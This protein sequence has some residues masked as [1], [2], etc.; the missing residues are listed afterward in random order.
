MLY[1]VPII[2]SSSAFGLR[3]GLL[4]VLAAFALM[5]PRALFISSNP[6]QAMWETLI[7]TAIGSTAPFGMERYKRQEAQLEVTR[8]RLESTQRE[9]VTKV[10]ISREQERQLLVINAFSAM[11]SQPL[12]LEQ[13]MKST[14]GMVMDLME[15]EVVMVFALYDKAESLRL[16]AYKGIGDSFAKHL[17]GM[18]LCENPCGRMIKTGEPF[19]LSDIAKG[20]ILHNL[21]VSGKSLK[22][23]LSVPLLAHGEVMGTLCVAASSGRHLKEPDIELLLALGKLIGIAIYNHYLYCERKT[24]TEKLELSEKKYRQLFENAHAAIWV[25]DL[26]GKVIE[27]NQAAAELFG[28]KLPGLIGADSR[29]LFSR[30]D[31]AVSAAVQKNLLS[32][33]RKQQPFRQE[34]IRRDGTKAYAMLTANLVSNNE[35]PSG[36]QFIGR[37]I[38]KEVR[39]QENER[40]YLQQITRAHEEERQRISR[41]LHDSTAQNLI[42]ILRLLE[43]FCEEDRQLSPHRLEVLWS[44]HGQ[45]KEVEQ[46]IRQLSRDLRPSVIDDL[47]L[48]PAVEWLIEQL[49][50]EHG[51]EANL[52]V[53]GKERRF[54]PE[55]EVVLFRIVQEALRNIARHAEATKSQITIAFRSNETGLTIVDNGKGFELPTSLGELSRFGKLGID[56]MQARVRLIGGTFSIYPEPGKGTTITVTIPA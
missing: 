26:A 12:E 31:L 35:H 50:K 18:K 44:L 19:I 52:T 10:Q 23:E 38:T 41:D 32:K 25:Q 49:R 45:L 53:L 46:E 20:S 55:N 39:M 40:F 29:E 8:D 30:E 21:S 14:V 9:L 17:D 37:D 4:A 28:Y 16:L 7:I 36:I 22:T 43:K 56:G 3:G 2:L 51:I 13:V 24:A 15:V 6:V 48:L 54:S 1:L 47:G 33:R 42:G 34:I 11:L 27:A 5:L